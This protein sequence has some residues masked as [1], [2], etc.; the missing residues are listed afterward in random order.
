MYNVQRTNSEHAHEIAAHVLDTALDL[1]D[2]LP[3]HLKQTLVQRRDTRLRR[4]VEIADDAPITL[5]ERNH[6]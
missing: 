5:G 2:A 1:I 6:G 3:L 4:L